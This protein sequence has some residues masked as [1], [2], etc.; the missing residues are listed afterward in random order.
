MVVGAAADGFGRV[1][2][3]GT[4]GRHR[5]GDV[6]HPVGRSGSPGT[7]DSKT[8]T[9]LERPVAMAGRQFLTQ[10]RESRSRKARGQERL[11][12]PPD[13]TAPAN[14]VHAPYRTDPGRK[15]LD[16]KRTS[17]IVD[18]ADGRIPPLTAD[19]QQRPARAGERPRRWAARMAPRIGAR[20]SAASRGACRLQRSR[21]CT[22]T[23]SRSCRRRTTVAII[24]EMVHDTAHRPARRTRAACSR[25]SPVVRQLARPLGRG[26]A[27]RRDRKL[28]RQ[29]ELPGIGRQ[30]C[31]LSSDSRASTP[32]R[33]ATS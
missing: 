29:D 5:E 16:D 33:S 4:D 11:D 31:T 15:V 3:C 30:A 6:P 12:Q 18:P 13:E 32:T 2:G 22:T 14:L 8:I 19:A 23:T 28:F 10:G 21:G 24:H 9:P 1:I 25:H 27:R 26:H 7:W 17:L 20:S